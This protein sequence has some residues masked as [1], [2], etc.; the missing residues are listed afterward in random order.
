MLKAQTLGRYS[1]VTFWRTKKVTSG[2]AQLICENINNINHI[3]ILTEIV[4][5]TFPLYD[6]YRYSLIHTEPGPT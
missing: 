5:P 2:L 1:K 3:N 4:W 6:I